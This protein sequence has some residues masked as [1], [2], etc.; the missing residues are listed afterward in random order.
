[1]DAAS[2]DSINENNDRS[3]NDDDNFFQ[4]YYAPF[5]LSKNHEDLSSGSEYDSEKQTF[6]S[7][8]NIILSFY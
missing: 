7:H 8:K 1:M 5:F 3:M 4:T 2:F 6:C